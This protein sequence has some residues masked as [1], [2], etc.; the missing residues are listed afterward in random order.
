MLNIKKKKKKLKSHKR[1]PEKSKNLRLIL[2][3]E[4]VYSLV[5]YFCLSHFFIGTAVELESLGITR[6]HWYHRSS[7]TL[8]EGATA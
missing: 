3:L 6:Y 4:L 5:A 7:G 2:I 8:T 1:K